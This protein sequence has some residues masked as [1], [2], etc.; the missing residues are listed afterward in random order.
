VG[1]AWRSTNAL[2]ASSTDS[3]EHS[4]TFKTSLAKTLIEK[5]SAPVFILSRPK[6]EQT[7]LEYFFFV[8]QSTRDQVSITQL[9]LQE[10]VRI[11]SHLPVALLDSAHLT[12]GKFSSCVTCSPFHC[13]QRFCLTAFSRVSAVSCTLMASLAASSR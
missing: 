13:P 6:T 7:V 12:A 5:L 8:R 4:P 11:D 1:E 3:R 10:L 2:Q 9:Q